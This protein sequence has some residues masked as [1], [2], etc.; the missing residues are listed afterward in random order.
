MGSSR[1]PG[2]VLMKVCGRSLL[3]LQY[4][5]I[6][7]A[8]KVD[9]I[10]VAT[11]SGASD[12]AIAQLCK[13][14]NIEYFQGSENDVLDRFYQ[15]ARQAGCVN[16]DSIIRVT[17][18]CPLLDPEVLDGVVDLFYTSGVDYASNINPPT[19]P[20]GLDVEIFNYKSLARAWREASLTSEREHVTPYIRTH[21]ELF[22]QANYSRASDLSDLRLTVDEPED[23]EIIRFIYESLYPQ[24]PLFLL[25]DVLQVIDQ[26]PSL[27]EINRGFARNEGYEKSLREDQLVRSGGKAHDA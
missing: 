8:V 1:L 11:T 12:D 13:N 21:P 24:K 17:G 5:R 20:D 2:K 27:L 7:A 23:L 15:A 18:D 22:S 19:F 10:I 3:E 25:A 14:Q 9:R 6:Q 26:N 4:E 16:G